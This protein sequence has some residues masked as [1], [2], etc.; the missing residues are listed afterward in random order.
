MVDIE[1]WSS[2]IALL[3]EKNLVVVFD[4][5]HSASA[6]SEGN[7]IAQFQK[8]IFKATFAD[9]TDQISQL[10]FISDFHNSA[11]SR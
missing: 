5:K 6:K 3:F 10:F 11:A 1:I 9:A 8:P 2:Y 4:L 7:E